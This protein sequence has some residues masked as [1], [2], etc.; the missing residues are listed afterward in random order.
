MIAGPR[1]DRQAHPSPTRHPTPAC[2]GGRRARWRDARRGPGVSHGSSLPFSRAAG[3][4]GTVGRAERRADGGEGKPSSSADRSGAHDL[5][6]CGLFPL[7]PR[8]SAGARFPPLP[9]RGKGRGWITP[10]FAEGSLVGRPPETTRP[11]VYSFGACCAALR[12][13]MPRMLAAW[14]RL[15][16][17]WLKGLDDQL[18]LHRGHRLA[19]KSPR[20]WRPSAGETTAG[21]CRR[22]GPAGSPART[23]G[24]P[25]GSRMALFLDFGGPEARQQPRGAWAFLQLTPRCPGPAVDRQAY[26]WPPVESRAA[27]GMPLA[28]GVFCVR[29]TRPAPGT[30]RLG[31][32]RAAAAGAGFTTFRA[33]ESR[34]LAETS[35]PSRPGPGRGLEVARDADVDLHRLGPARPGRSRA[36]PE[37]GA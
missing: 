13:E 7:H 17:Q 35:R 19:D 15:P 28:A 25:S 37:P 16:R 23:G 24:W 32:L 36:I 4:G 30:V 10:A 34:S 26:A 5:C 18:L 31:R 8:P 2:R 11:S 1:P 21:P 20:G 33:V 27:S 14:V 22:A 12:I 3:E 6:R 9:L 29:R